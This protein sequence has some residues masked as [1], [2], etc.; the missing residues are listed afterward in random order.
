MYDSHWGRERRGKI[1]NLFRPNN[2]K[3]GPPIT[4]TSEIKKRVDLEW[5]SVN[6]D[7]LLSPRRLHFDSTSGGAWCPANPLS[8]EN[9][10][11][12]YLQIDLGDLKVITHALSQGRF[13]S[14]R[15]Q[16]YA[17]FY[18][19]KYWRSGM[20]DFKEYRDALGRAV[21]TYIHSLNE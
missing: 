14:G 5:N 11:A 20:T 4:E 18:T 16:E 9:L 8:K 19:I 7:A 15:G 10:G 1:L 17:E 21:S 2:G 6:V 13:G 3:N 12:E